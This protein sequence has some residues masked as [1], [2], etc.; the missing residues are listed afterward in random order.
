MTSYFAIL[1]AV[2]VLASVMLARNQLVFSIR[3]K[4]INAI[5]AKNESD[6]GN[7]DFTRVMTRRYSELD[8][9]SYNAMLFDARRWTYRQFYPAEVA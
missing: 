3:M 2:L 4:R 5:H 8:S 7:P 9:P 6:I 1:T